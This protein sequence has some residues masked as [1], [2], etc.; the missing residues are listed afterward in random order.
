MSIIKKDNPKP[1]K[2]VSF[3]LPDN[4]DEGNE[5]DYE[6]ENPEAT[7]R[8]LVGRQRFKVEEYGDDYE[9][10][11]ELRR[12]AEMAFN[13]GKELFSQTQL[14]LQ[15]PEKDPL[16]LEQKNDFKKIMG[17]E[18]DQHQNA[19]PKCSEIMTIQYNH[20]QVCSRETVDVRCPNCV[21]D[22]FDLCSEKCQ[23]VFQGNIG[24]VEIKDPNGKT[25]IVIEDDDGTLVL[26]VTDHSLF[27]SQLNQKDSLNINKNCQNCYPEDKEEEDIDP[28]LIQKVGVVPLKCE[29]CSEN[30]SYL[31]ACLKCYQQSGLKYICDECES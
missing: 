2:R 31:I 1:V 24:V 20:C 15:M 5:T 22:L 21:P 28:D 7:F 6:D 16:E 3:D 27:Y 8:K 10:T 4:P 9:S 29:Y 23:N 17:K 13:Y 25:F 26:R 19:C 12:N 30:Y 11:A 18:Y 14:E